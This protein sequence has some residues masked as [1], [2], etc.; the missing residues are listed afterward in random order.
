M[1]EVTVLYL[2]SAAI[3]ICLGVVLIAAIRGSMKKFKR[4]VN[5][6]KDL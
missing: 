4:W 2:M 3:L 1:R 6:G 5:N